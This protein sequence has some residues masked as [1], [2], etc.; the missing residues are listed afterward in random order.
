MS[1]FT[2]ARLESC[3]LFR[4]VPMKAIIWNCNKQPKALRSR[5]EGSE[6]LRIGFIGRLDRLKGIEVLLQAAAALPAGRVLIAGRGETEYEGILKARA[7]NL[8]VEFLGFV[9]PAVFYRGIDVLV[10]P[11]LWNEPL[12]RVIPEAMGYGIPVV[13]ADIGGM[14]E[15][16]SA[17][18][19]G[20][21][22]PPGDANELA[23][24]LQRLEDRDLLDRMSAN[25][26]AASAQFRFEG[27][28]NAYENVWRAVY[29]QKAGATS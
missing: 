3:G 5:G 23:K 17:G 4:D 15:I 7:R 14:P 19:T 28:Y 1:R 26:A 6:R 25:A 11:S 2:L 24:C 27:I 9:E 22:F 8:N 29:D 18:K 16:V 13:C 12:P 21:L 20:L 10:V